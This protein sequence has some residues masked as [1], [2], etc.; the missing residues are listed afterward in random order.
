MEKRVVSAVLNIVYLLEFDMQDSFIR[1]KVS[2][3][4][5]E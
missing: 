3:T 5:N 4:G 2:S 1:P